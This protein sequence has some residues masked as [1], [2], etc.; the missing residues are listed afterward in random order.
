VIIVH[1]RAAASVREAVSALI[2]D[3]DASGISL[4]VVVADN[5]STRQE[6]ALLQSL[7]VVYL[8]IGRNAGYAGALKIAFPM[9]TSDSIVVM[10]EDLIV[11]PG[12]LHALN[13]ALMN[14]A[15]VAGPELYWDRDCTFRL[16]CSEERTRQNELLK[17]AA[18]SDLHKL[19]RARKRWR[20]HARRHWRSRSPLATT[21]LSGALL[22]F[23]RDTWTAD[24]PFDDSYALYFE[25]NDW[26]LRVARAG[27]RSVFVPAAKAIHL[28]NPSLAQTPERL[29][30]WA[31][32]F[33]RFG[34]R[35]YG[36]EFM[37][38]LFFLAQGADVTPDWREMNDGSIRIDCVASDSWPVWVEL[39]PS[40]FG[41]PAAATCITHLKDRC[42]S[43][44]PMRG[45]QFLD[46]PLYL[47]LVDDPGRELGRYRLPALHSLRQRES[48]AV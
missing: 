37:Q 27:F 23:R 10:N 48:L 32:S 46:G 22:A 20:E 21:A 36:K 45:L 19:A 25:E 4:N 44:P 43:L 24:G 17:A 29:Q 28:H 34:N 26:L 7:D 5:G 39:T 38:R 9:T 30:M 13:V 6:R 40:P 15:A 42:W 47:Q 33:E 8:D 11:L 16:P 35:Y 31:E 2:A 1:Y 18:R 41:F 3:A 12:C 14:G